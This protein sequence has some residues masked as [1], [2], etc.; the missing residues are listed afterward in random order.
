MILVSYKLIVEQSVAFQVEEEGEDHDDSEKSVAASVVEEEEEGEDD[1][2]VDNPPLKDDPKYA[3][4]FKLL[5]MV[6]VCGCL[7]RLLHLYVTM[8]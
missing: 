7:I 4:Y 3:K 2:E 6:S 1:D 8:C 5:K